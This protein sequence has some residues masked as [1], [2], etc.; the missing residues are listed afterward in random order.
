MAGLC[1]AL[2]FL[3]TGCYFQPGKFEADLVVRR[4]GS[5][6][7]HY[8]GEL[9][10]AYPND[11]RQKDWDPEKVRCQDELMG[12]ERPCTP[13]EIDVERA[14][15]QLAENARRA[16][17]AEIAAFTGFN[18]YDDSANKALAAQMQGT[19]GW[20]R[21]EYEGRGVFDV[22]YEVSGMLNRD[23]LFPVLPQAKLLIP[24]MVARRTDGGLVEIEAPGFS[25][26]AIRNI[27]MNS[28][29]DKSGE[30][31][32]PVTNL[33]YGTFTIKTDAELTFTNGR[34][35]RDTASNNPGSTRWKTTF[36]NVEGS[37]NESPK[38][39]I[40]LDD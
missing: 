20:N 3:L 11:G 31:V 19:R 6:T 32:M 8:V 14:S 12:N 1:L 4:D 17:A 15:F 24:I 7:Y 22:D 9:I 40:G 13:I 18:F 35:N 26:T 16:N 36:W 10:F 21:V 28:L 34:M 37:L 29:G 30:V 5:F 33:A 25:T 2:C 23:F 39:Q 38:V 27:L